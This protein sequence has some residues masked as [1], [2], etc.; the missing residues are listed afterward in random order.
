M[1]RCYIFHDDQVTEYPAWPA[2]EG[3]PLGSYSYEPDEFFPDQRWGQMTQTKRESA[4][5]EA[6]EFRFI[7]EID[8]PT[9]V[10]SLY[11]TMALLLS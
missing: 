1:S 3:C 10:P 4:L 8:V 6:K 11:L 5:L 7:D 9:T 2:H